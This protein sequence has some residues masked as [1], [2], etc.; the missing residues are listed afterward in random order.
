[1]K[2]INHKYTLKYKT[3]CTFIFSQDPKKFA[4]AILF[5]VEFSLYTR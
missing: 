2:I 5:I 1:M 3:V 4:K